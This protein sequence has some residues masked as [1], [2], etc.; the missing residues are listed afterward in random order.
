MGSEG[1]TCR[2]MGGCCLYADTP[3]DGQCSCGTSRSDATAHRIPCKVTL[4]EDDGI[5]WMQGLTIWVII[6]DM[7]CF[8]LMRCRS[9]WCMWVHHVET[10]ITSTDIRE[11]SW[12]SIQY[13][14]VVL[15]P[16]K[17]V[18]CCYLGLYWSIAVW[19][20]VF[21]W[22]KWSNHQWSC[23]SA[24]LVGVVIN[25]KQKILRLMQYYITNPSNKE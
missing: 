11:I 12:E 15:K 1:S 18:R 7:K 3:V 13:K 10:M 9:K 19:A 22:H 16:V 25:S 4:A 20:S 8:L 17:P 24:F 2:F 21:R 5:P 14:V 23:Q 6:R